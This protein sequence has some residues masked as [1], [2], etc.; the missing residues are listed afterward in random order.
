[1]SQKEIVLQVI[2]ELPLRLVLSIT[3]FKIDYGCCRQ[4]LES[5][6]MF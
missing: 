5:P 4:I 3:Y 1:M 2:Q 6:I